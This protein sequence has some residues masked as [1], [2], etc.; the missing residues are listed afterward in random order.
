MTIRSTQASIRTLVGGG[1][2]EHRVTQASLRLLQQEVMPDAPVLEASADGDTISASTSPFSSSRQGAEHTATE[3]QFQLAGGNWSSPITPPSGVEEGDVT[4]GFWTSE[5]GVPANEN[6]DVRARHYDGDLISPWSNVVTVQTGDALPV[7]DQPTIT[8]LDDDFE[9]RVQVEQSAFSHPDGVADGPGGEEPDEEAEEEPEELPWH[10]ASEF[11][12]RVQG[13]AVVYDPGPEPGRTD[14]VQWFEGLTADTTYEI[15]VRHQDGLHGTFSPWSAWVAFATADEPAVRPDTPALTLVECS[16]EKLA[17]E[18]DGAYSHPEASAHTAS[19][20]WLCS[21]TDASPGVCSSFDTTEASELTEMEWPDPGGGAVSVGLQVRDEEGRWSLR[22][23]L[24]VCEIDPAPPQPFFVG[25]LGAIS[26]E[27]LI[28][29][30]V[31]DDGTYDYDG[32]LSADGGQTWGTLFSEQAAKEHIFDPTGLANGEYLMRVRACNEDACSEWVYT[33]IVIDRTG[34]VVVPYDFAALDEFP[35]TWEVL[36]GWDGGAVTWSLVGP[37]LDSTGPT[38]GILAHNPQKNVQHNSVLAFRELGQ[39][40]E[41]DM[42]VV[43]SVVPRS[44]IAY[45]WRFPHANRLQGGVAYSARSPA[46][47]QAAGDG[48][49]KSGLIALARGG[50]GTWYGPPDTDSCDTPVF[51]LRE[52]DC[53][54]VNC[55]QCAGLTVERRNLALSNLT[56]LYRYAD[57]GSN[58]GAV[59]WGWRANRSVFFRWRDEEVPFAGSRSRGMSY[60]RIVPMGTLGECF[61]VFPRY[62]LQVRVR[63]LADG[64]TARIQS[65][66]V[67]P[68][69]DPSE[70]WTLTSDNHLGDVPCGACGLAFRHLQNLSQDHGILFHCATISNLAYGE[71][72]GEVTPCPDSAIQIAGF[73]RGVEQGAGNGNG[74]GNGNGN[75]AA[76]GNG[77]GNGNG[78]GKTGERTHRSRRGLPRRGGLGRDRAYGHDPERPGS[79]P[80]VH[81]DEHERLGRGQLP[82]GAGGRAFGT[83]QRAQGHHF[84]GERDGN[85]QQLYVR[86]GV[87]ERY[88]HDQEP[89]HRRPDG[90][91]EGVR[92]RG[93]APAHLPCRALGWSG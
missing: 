78:N 83:R 44:A 81:G 29:W 36:G 34:A 47:N 27:T 57:A 7:P 42:S 58:A 18:M 65:R 51:G 1:T 26:E 89:L 9:D 43:L 23:P 76:P 68:G 48:D 6:V 39:P 24:V 41:V 5:E 21:G 63:M 86:A 87:F 74:D 45:W 82:S 3:W 56:R 85:G 79:R 20:W 49:H 11:E 70:G 71:C 31:P 8:I 22:S 15:R 84:S 12:I 60:A 64:E 50:V 17:V 19:R 28:E 73:S 30:D 69:L 77:N 53:G 54:F 16:L 72:G 67:G 55:V 62:L 37:N 33:P 13:G 10:L 91:G 46:E 88:P 35:A 92:N 4:A 66:L 32:E 90:S 2:G 59:L 93:H 52:C 75:G 38:V 25:C 61:W 80:T 14:P 40:R